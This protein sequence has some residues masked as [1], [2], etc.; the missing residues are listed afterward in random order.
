MT[1][2][3]GTP[4]GDTLPNLGPSHGLPD[5]DLHGPHQDERAAGSL[6]LPYGDGAKT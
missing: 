4:P 1:L 2:A 6:V 5:A 3:R